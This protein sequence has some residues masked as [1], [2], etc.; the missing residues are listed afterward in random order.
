MGPPLATLQD[1]VLAGVYALSTV[2]FAKRY[3]DVA[4]IRSH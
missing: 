3:G 2:G 1:R 4:K